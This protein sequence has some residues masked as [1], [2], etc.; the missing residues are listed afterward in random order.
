MG[1][2]ES[3]PFFCEASETGRDVT[4][5]YTETPVGSLPMHKFMKYTTTGEDYKNLTPRNEGNSFGYMW[6]VY[7]DN[8]IALA[9]PTSKD[10]LDHVADAILK[11]IHEVFPEDDND[12]EDPI[13][14]K[15]FLKREGMWATMKDILDF[16]FNGINKTL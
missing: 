6:E 16:N 10:Q 3:P 1:W 2:I 14:L 4:A 7:V 15:K 5:Q 13:S 11:G 9:V 8:Y 12:S